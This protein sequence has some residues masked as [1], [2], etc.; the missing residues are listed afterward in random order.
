MKV[1]CDISL[2]KAER[3]TSQ[4]TLRLR[5]KGEPTHSLRLRVGSPFFSRK[6]Y[7][8]ANLS[9][10]RKFNPFRPCGKMRTAH[11]IGHAW[12]K[13]DFAALYSQ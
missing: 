8:M 10:A 2:R 11:F 9:F 13:C 1:F 6:V 7:I 12:Q 3:L 4:N 5:F